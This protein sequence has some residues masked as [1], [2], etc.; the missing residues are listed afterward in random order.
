M[1]W[2]RHGGR[3]RA[4]WG[5]GAQP[6]C[7]TTGGWCLFAAAAPRPLPAAQLPLPAITWLQRRAGQLHQRPGGQGGGAGGARAAPGGAGGCWAVGWACCGR[8][9]GGSGVDGLQVGRQCAWRAYGWTQLR[10]ETPPSPL[11][12]LSCCCPFP[13]LPAL[14]Q[15]RALEMARGELG[16]SRSR[17]QLIEQELQVGQGLCGGQPVR[18]T[19]SCLHPPLWARW[20]ENKARVLGCP[21]RRWWRPSQPSPNASCC[22]P[23]AT[24]RQMGS[25]Q[26][27]LERVGAVAVAFARAFV[28]LSPTAAEPAPPC[29]Q[30]A[31]TG[32]CCSSS[33]SVRSGPSCPPSLVP[34]L[35]ARYDLVAARYG[36][37]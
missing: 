18:A 21:A 37:D 16:S 20:A 8:R 1:S 13:R 17:L 30:C 33:C 3:G 12:T 31:Y 36:I 11:L 5:R 25:Q 2:R 28:L 10:F 6:P 15:Q 34:A 32:D 26:E 24:R 19:A 9:L 27:Q 35:Q 22:R 4:C 23:Q 7:R 29:M 14:P